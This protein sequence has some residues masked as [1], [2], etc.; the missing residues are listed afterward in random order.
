MKVWGEQF[1]TA[2]SEIGD[3]RSIIPANVNIMALTATAT[4]ETFHIVTRK[5][6]MSD[7]ELIA[8]PPNHDNIFYRVHPKNNL[9]ELSA[10]LSEEFRQGDVLKTCV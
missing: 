8:L 4:C 6:S 9:E 10:S 3:L 2:F 7:S 1:R 5:L